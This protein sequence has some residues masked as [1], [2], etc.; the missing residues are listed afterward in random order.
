MRQKRSLGFTLVE[1]LVVIAIIGILIGM[2]LP[3]VQQVREAARRT[4][5]MNNLRQQAIAMH[6]YQSTFS[7]FP[8]GFSGWGNSTHQ[9]GEPLYTP[10]GWRGL[11]NYWGWG[12]F[13]LP[14]LE[15][16][17]LLELIEVS[18][19]SR[20]N[21]LYEQFGL[22][23]VDAN[24]RPIGSFTIPVY[25]CPTDA[26]P[27]QNQM[28]TEDT[29]L[30][31]YGKSNYVANA[32][33]IWESYSTTT[34][35]GPNHEWRGMFMMNISTS[36][37]DCSDGSSN[38]VLLG[39]R[40]GEIEDITLTS[41]GFANQGAIWMGRFN[42]FNISHLDNTTI[43]PGFSCMGRTGGTDH[44]VN[45]PHWGRGVAS[46]SHPAGANVALTDASVQFLND[47][48]DITALEDISMRADGAVVSGF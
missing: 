15:Q 46:S 32:G 20:T 42:R 11:G 23:Q 39:E 8:A 18:G 16:K 2:L 35:Y 30:G 1:L 48:T 17:N 22:D 38:V 12:A 41:D 45:G 5:C 6:N 29:T 26:E 7:E 4:T 9:F 19:I 13:I 44:A 28:Y 34:V 10:Y 14:Q 21:G 25:M 43:R 31:F 24:G 36:F 40:R 33:K 37:E 27:D 3:A 47:N